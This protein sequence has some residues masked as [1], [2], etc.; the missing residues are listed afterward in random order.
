M[1][2]LKKYEDISKNPY[3]V[4]RDEEEKYQSELDKRYN[5]EKESID[6]I[7]ERRGYEKTL[8]YVDEYSEISNYFDNEVEKIIEKIDSDLKK[9]DLEYILHYIN[10]DPEWVREFVEEKYTDKLLLIDRWLYE[11]DKSKTQEDGDSILEE[12]CY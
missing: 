10:L 4:T 5:L 8:K 1:K 9:Y 11:I 7:I 2:H 6:E 12:L 3:L